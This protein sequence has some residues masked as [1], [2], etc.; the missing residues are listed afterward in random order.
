[1]NKNKHTFLVKVGWSSALK[2]SKLD[3]IVKSIVTTLPHLDV[4]YKGS[5]KA[6][7]SLEAWVYIYAITV[8]K[9]EDETL[10]LLKSGFNKHV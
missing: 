1:M 3:D 2:I 6:D 7:E 4:E 8:A 5:L 9:P 10:F